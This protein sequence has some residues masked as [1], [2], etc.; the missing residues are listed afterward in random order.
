MAFAK[1]IEGFSPLIATA[2]SAPTATAALMPLAPV[3]LNP[4]TSTAAAAAAAGARKLL[5]SC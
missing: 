4:R 5:G 3:V 1:A 2:F